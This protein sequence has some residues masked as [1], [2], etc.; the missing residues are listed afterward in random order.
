MGK[1]CIQQSVDQVSHS[2]IGD[3]VIRGG[4]CHKIKSLNDPSPQ[5]Q[6]G[7][8]HPILLLSSQVHA[9]GL[10]YH[11][12]K[13]QNQGFCHGGRCGSGEESALQMLECTLG[14]HPRCLIQAWVTPGRRLPGMPP[15]LILVEGKWDTPLIRLTRGSHGLKVWLIL[16]C[17]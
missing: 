2:P 1:D 12:G 15:L 17:F 9:Q 8:Q 6:S 13:Y 5:A 16:G 14:R 10:S 7:W 3:G 4:G 11:P